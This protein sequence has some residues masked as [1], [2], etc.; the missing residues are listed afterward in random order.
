LITPVI[1]LTIALSIAVIFVV[2]L[3]AGA[4]A[5]RPGG[6]LLRLTQ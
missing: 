3:D 6:P 2:M 4:T 5:V 1:A